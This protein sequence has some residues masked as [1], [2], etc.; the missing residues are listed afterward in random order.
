MLD[1]VVDVVAGAELLEVLR[2]RVPDAARVRVAQF[3][4]A[5]LVERRE[6]G[7]DHCLV[8]ALL[9]GEN[10]RDVG[11][12][13][14]V[15]DHAGFCARPLLARPG[16]PGGALRAGVGV[17]NTLADFDRLLAGLGAPTPPCSPRRWLRPG[18]RLTP[19][20]WSTVLNPPAG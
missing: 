20:E 8:A 7:V 2:L 3:I 11:F 16:I 18:R 5:Q 1:P 10:G 13:G 17:G 12:I 6:V 9:G 15:R 4:R 19:R 14:H